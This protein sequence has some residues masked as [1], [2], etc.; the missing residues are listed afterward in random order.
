[1]SEPGLA[2]GEAATSGMLANTR[3]RDPG[4]S[5]VNEVSHRHGKQVL[6]RQR[7]VA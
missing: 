3:E 4:R 5:R 7:N 6:S 2:S 1:V